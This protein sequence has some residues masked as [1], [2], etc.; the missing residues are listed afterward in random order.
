MCAGMSSGPSTVCI[1]PGSFSGTSL[2]M[3]YPMSLATSGSAFSLIVIAAE[4]CLIKR[5]SSPDSGKSLRFFSIWPV[6]R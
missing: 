6:I 5:L 1:Y 2:S 3:A 4:V